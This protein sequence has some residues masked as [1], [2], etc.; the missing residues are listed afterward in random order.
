[1]IVT[2]PLKQV[3]S[4]QRGIFDA[5]VT[6]APIIDTS[7]YYP[8]QRDGWIDEIENGMTE[9]RWVEQHV[10]PPVIKVFNNSAARRHNSQNRS[11]TKL[12][13]SRGGRM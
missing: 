2:I 6:G 4:L 11:G 3:P 8:Q 1:V 13:D 12:C 10:G 9:A 7:N 5:R